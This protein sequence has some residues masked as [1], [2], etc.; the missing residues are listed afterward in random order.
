MAKFPSKRGGTGRG[1]KSPKT[2]GFLPDFA[3]PTKG[4][5]SAPPKTFWMGGRPIAGR[6]APLKVP[7]ETPRSNQAWTSHPADS[8]QR[9]FGVHEPPSLLL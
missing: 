3:K 9:S 8:R 6:F 7:P 1:S 4:K 2:P 5:S